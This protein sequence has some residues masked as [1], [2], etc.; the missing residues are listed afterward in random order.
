MSSNLHIVT[1][2]T[3]SKY[4]FP[5]L[6]ES[7]KR[8]GKDLEVI[9]HGEKWQ[10]FNWRYK[11][12]MEYL[13]ERKP[14]DIVCVVDGYDVICTRNLNEMKK[15]FLDI[16]ERTKCKMVVAHEKLFFINNLGNYYFS[17]CKNL[18][19]NAGT[20]IAHAKDMLSIVK[21]IYDLNPKD[22][23]DDQVLLTKF[24]QSSA[25]DIY[26]DVKGE[27][28]LTISHSL[29]DLEQHITYKKDSVVYNGVRP[30][31]IHAPGFGYLDNIIVHLGYSNNCNVRN[32]LFTN[33]FKEKALLYLSFVFHWYI[34]LAILIAVLLFLSFYHK[35]FLLKFFK[36]INRYIKYKK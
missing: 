33:F 11:K 2:S 1:V 17:H 23:A 14:N 6:I 9:G 15:V 10:G 21:K 22:D 3:G 16:K 34:L 24:C 4:Y 29:H 8:Q 26:I 7:C 36:K 25:K 27:L 35:Q 13:K 12:M 5:Y 19:L 20:Y 32:D 31:F 18:S 28:F 30:F